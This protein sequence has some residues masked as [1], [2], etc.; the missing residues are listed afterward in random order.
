QFEVIM[1][2][3]NVLIAKN[4]ELEN[5]IAIKD[6]ELAF[7]KEQIAY[8][9]QKLY[10]PKKESLDFNPNQGNLFDDQLFI[11][12][13]HTGDQSDEEVIIKAYGRK[14]RKGLKQAQLN[15]LPTIDHIHEIEACSCPEC[16]EVMK[17]ISTTLVRQEVKYFPARMENHRHF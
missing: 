8:L 14:K 2:K 1:D 3:L 13:E 15:H 6:D 11:E 17:E 5:S 9:T 4:S 16:Q 10:G 12:P 7:L